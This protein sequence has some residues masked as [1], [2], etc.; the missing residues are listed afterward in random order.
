MKKLQLD[1]EALVVMTFA[2]EAPQA[3]APAA[4][5]SEEITDCTCARPFCPPL[6]SVNIC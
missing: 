1:P 3:A 2:T 6:P 4:A 5:V